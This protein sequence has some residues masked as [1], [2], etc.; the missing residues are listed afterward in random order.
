MDYKIEK[1]VPIPTQKGR[2]RGT[3]KYPFAEMNVGDSFTIP[4]DKNKDT[5]WTKQTSLKQSARRWALLNGKKWDFQTTKEEHT[6]R[7][8]RIK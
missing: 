1:K 2:R 6:I 8:W 7:I 3:S 4:Y 5:Y